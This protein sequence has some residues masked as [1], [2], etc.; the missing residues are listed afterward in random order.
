VSALGPFL[1]FARRTPD[2]ILILLFFRP[3]LAA[4]PFLLRF[5]F[6]LAR[7]TG[8]ERFSGSLWVPASISLGLDLKSKSEDWVAPAKTILYPIIDLYEEERSSESG[9]GKWNLEG[10][11]IHLAL[12]LERL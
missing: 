12:R 1:V 7:F 9:R 8:C 11:T 4:F 3:C 6:S 5:F 10:F 2:C